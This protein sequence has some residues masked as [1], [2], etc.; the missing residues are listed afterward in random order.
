M[1]FESAKVGRKSF[2]EGLEFDGSVLGQF[3][4]DFDPVKSNVFLGLA[5]LTK[6]TRDF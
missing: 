1:L 5:T 6:S 3:L 4:S 2:F